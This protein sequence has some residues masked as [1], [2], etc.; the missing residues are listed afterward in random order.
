MK[1]DYIDEIPELRPGE[2]NTISASEEVSEEPKEERL[3]DFPLLSGDN[4][5][6]KYVM[7][8]PERFKKLWV[9]KP[10]D[11]L[12]DYPSRFMKFRRI[13][14]IDIIKPFL[15]DQNGTLVPG[16]PYDWFYNAF[17]GNPENNLEPLFPLLNVRNN[18]GD[19]DFDYLLADKIISYGDIHLIDLW[20]CEHFDNGITLR[21]FA[22]KDLP[23]WLSFLKSRIPTELVSEEIMEKNAPSIIKLKGL[24]KRNP[25]D[26]KI[27]E[28]L[29][30]V[31]ETLGCYLPGDIILICPK[32]IRK[33][34]NDLSIDPDILFCIV[35]IHELAHAAMDQSIDAKEILYY[36]DYKYSIIKTNGVYE[37][38]DASNFMEESLAN[39]I[40]LKYLKL[41]SEIEMN[42]S[43]FDTAV[44]FVSQ[45]APM[46]KSG[47][48]Q[49][50]INADWTK[51]REYKSKKK[52]AEIELEEWYKKNAEDDNP[53]TLE[54]FN[55]LF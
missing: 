37:F 2:D 23:L 44:K 42:E 30:E 22:N 4:K 32:R 54:D 5:I 29:S 18:S 8:F 14:G 40:M 11:E 24:V 47:L 10:T 43:F 3:T 33:V 17:M 41:Y 7:R 51:W 13:K 46:Y 45:Q 48:R 9:I 31:M 12:A 39:L 35:Y 16:V 26:E 15:I 38:D 21:I 25:N 55:S 20:W 53:Y 52:K 49:F 34:A 50:E 19:L 1:P 27:I 28:N 6:G 36:G